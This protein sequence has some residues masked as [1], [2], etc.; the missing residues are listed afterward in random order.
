MY[1]REFM[2]QAQGVSCY[3]VLWLAGIG[4]YTSSCVCSLWYIVHRVILDNTLRPCYQ[5]NRW[6]V[7]LNSGCSWITWFWINILQAQKLFLFDLVKHVFSVPNGDQTSCYKWV[8]YTLYASNVVLTAIYTCNN[9]AYSSEF[10]WIL[11]VKNAVTISH[12]ENEK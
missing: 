1:V 6:S 7:Q 2:D 3:N 5:T 9:G 4:V 12:L 11:S 8:F 10:I